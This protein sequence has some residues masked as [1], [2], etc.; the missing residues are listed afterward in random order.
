MQ[1]MDEELLPHGTLRGA[2]SSS[3]A[4]TISS[5]VD[6][7]LVPHGT[8][9]GA[10]S[11]SSARTISSQM[12]EELLP[13][14]TLR[15]ALTSLSARTSSSQAGSELEFRR[16]SSCQVRQGLSLTFAGAL[17]VSYVRALGICEC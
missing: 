9:R 4:R 10:L 5:Q 17:H 11:S 14:G 12:D 1:E 13:D 15:G 8:L 6:E 3:S 7:E 16:S 2:L